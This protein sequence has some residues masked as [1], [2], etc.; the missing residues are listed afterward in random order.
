M[1]RPIDRDAREGQGSRGA[2]VNT[3]IPARMDRL[4]WSRWHWLVII[5]LG[6]TWV[7]DGLEVTI[8]GA[9]A[10]ILKEP[11]TLHF[12]DADVGNAATAYLIGAVVGALFFGRLTDILGRKKLFMITLSLYLVATVL[13]AFSF[14]FFWFAIFRVLTGAGIGGEYAAVN[15]AVDEL[16]PAR[17]RGWADLAIN[18]SWWGGTALGALAT[19]FL[20]NPHFLPVDLG[21]RLA[22]AIGALL[23]LAILLV[24]RFVPE[25]PPST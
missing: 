11:Q 6:I 3:N 15:S 14:N 4:P 8:V 12:S 9:I 24:R 19:V 5:S 21:W 1:T 7:L 13:T 25:S 18:G 22:F 2:G 20:V 10:S 16:I 17:V 23:G